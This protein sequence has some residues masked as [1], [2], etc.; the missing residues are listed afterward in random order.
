MKLIF[1]SR[2][3]QIFIKDGCNHAPRIGE[4][5]DMFYEPKPAVS[6]V[7]NFPSA[8]TLKDA[9]MPPNSCA[10]AIILLD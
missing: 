9:G 1:I 6:Q 8:K 3:G 4:R 5:V 10:D 2:F 7:V